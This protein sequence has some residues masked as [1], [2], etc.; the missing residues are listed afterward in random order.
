MNNFY[1]WYMTFF[2]GFSLQAWDTLHKHKTYQTL[3]ENTID[4]KEQ[5]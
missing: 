3:K 4:Q 2:Y 1:T 5:K